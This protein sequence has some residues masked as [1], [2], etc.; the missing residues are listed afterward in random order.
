MTTVEY[1][2]THNNVVHVLQ[3]KPSNNSKIGT[4]F[5]IQTYHFSIEQV[6]NNNLKLDSGTCFDCPFSYNHNGEKSGGCYCHKGTQYIGLKSMLNRLNRLNIGPLCNDK[7]NSYLTISKELKPSLTRLG[8]YGEATT[9]PLN[10]VGKLC[11]LSPKHSGYTHQWVKVQGYSKYL[12]ASTHNVFETS[13]ANSLGFRS[14]S[15][16]GSGATC[17][18]AKEF[19]GN[20]KTCI[21]CGACDGTVKGKRNNITIKKH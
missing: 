8:T 2:F 1:I 20:K 4:G 5:V 16:N 21:Q 7:L 12:M 13:L 10:I 14:F 19:K 3:T 11:R 15:V 9:L 17:P 6:V 18:A